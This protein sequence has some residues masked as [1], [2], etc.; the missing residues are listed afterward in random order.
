MAVHFHETYAS[1]ID[2][3]YRSE[4]LTMGALCESYDWSGAKKVRLIT[5][6][7]VAMGDYTR[8]GA[9]RFGVPQEMQ[10]TVQEMT[11]TQD[12]AFALTI[13]KGNNADQ[14]GIKAAGEMLALQIAERA[15]PMF[16]KYVLS[17]LAHC[18]GNIVGSSEP[19]TKE[20]ICSR[21]TEGTKILDDHEVPDSDRTLFISSALGSTLRTSGEFL[22]VEGIAQQSIRQGMI[23]YFEGMRVVKIP[24]ARWP[25]GLNFLIVHKNA[26]TA[27]IKLSDTR[28][29]QDPPGIS[30]NLL[31]G[32]QYYDCF[33]FG[34]KC[35]GVYAEVDT[36]AVTLFEAPTINANGTVTASGDAVVYYTLDGSDP[37]YS[38]AAQVYSGA[39]SA[40]GKTMRAYATQSGDTA[41]SSAVS[42]QVL[43]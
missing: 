22:A 6:L 23:G 16:D 31:E 3:H 26:A 17:R 2:A 41:Y 4:S 20:N 12:K 36:S 21:I 13:D 5:P 8:E 32:R 19:L 18:A 25:K 29:H 38:S 40:P 28:Y 30:G 7:T 37:R 1:E 33:V 10:D 24:S 42:E 39:V 11:L 14:G 15:V 27:P 35:D 34:A 9:N 43:S